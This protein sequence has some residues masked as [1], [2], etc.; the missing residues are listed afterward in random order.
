MDETVD[1]VKI[2][3][4]FAGELHTKGRTQARQ[5]KAGIFYAI[6]ASIR[7]SVTPCRRLM[8]RLPFGCS[9][10]GSAEPFFFARHSNPSVMNYTE[11]HRPIT[12]EGI[13]DEICKSD[14]IPAIKQ[15]LTDLLLEYVCSETID[16]G[17]R[18]TAVFHYRILLEA[19]ND[20]ERLNLNQRRAAV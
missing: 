19:L 9:S 18:Q 6:Q 7:G 15:T 4:M 5:P 11:N 10:T 14:E 13:V 17:T 12:A 3:R 1:G 2:I 8:P 16:L 20:M